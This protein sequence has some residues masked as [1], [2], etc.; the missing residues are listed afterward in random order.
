[1]LERGA[2]I[3]SSYPSISQTSMVYSLHPG[4]FCMFLLSTDLFSKYSFR[5]RMVG[6]I[7]FII[8]SPA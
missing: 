5:N 1:M 8:D 6:T 3:V 4:K 7:T 2:S